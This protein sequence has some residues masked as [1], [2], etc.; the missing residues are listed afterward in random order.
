[1]PVVSAHDR[2]GLYSTFDRRPGHMHPM[3]TALR[4]R[5]AGS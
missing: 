2:P 1:M 5:G 4:S 3:K